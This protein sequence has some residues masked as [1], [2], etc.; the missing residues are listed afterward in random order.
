MKTIIPRE[1][2]FGKWLSDAAGDLS[3]GSIA[4]DV[5]RI[6]AGAIARSKRLKDDRA[7]SHGGYAPA[8][9]IGLYRRGAKVPGSTMALR[10][11]VA[12]RTLKA[13][14]CGSEALLQ[15][16]HVRDYVGG[17]GLFAL[18]TSSSDSRTRLLL[19]QAAVSESPSSFKEFLTP[20]QRV[21][22]DKDTEEWMSSRSPEKLHAYWQALYALVGIKNAAGREIARRYVSGWV[23]VLR[24][25]EAE[26]AVTEWAQG[27]GIEAAIAAQ[28]AHKRGV[29]KDP[30][31]AKD[32]V[33]A[34]LEET[35]KPPY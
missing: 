12:M 15:A 28:E 32:D 11:G 14:T 31:S 20:D 8:R 35:G 30:F 5:A 13:P 10:I 4:R 2:L 18:G 6:K 34:M 7:T 1:Q 17:C 33:V 16:G 9:E 21:A 23:D 3:N 27:G 24:L 29:V 19:A 26:E 25:H 22:L